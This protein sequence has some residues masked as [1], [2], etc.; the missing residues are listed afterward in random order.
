LSLAS[1]LAASVT[2]TS[3]VLKNPCEV[4]LVKADITSLNVD[5]VVNAA[6]NGL[7]RGAGVCGSIFQA[8][9]PRLDVACAALNGCATGDAVLTESFDMRNVKAIVHA[10]GPQVKGPLTDLH[11]HQLACCYARCLDV[12]S[13]HGLTSIVCF[14]L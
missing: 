2:T 10:V 11:R 14:S 5:A 9:G 7:C 12:A 6:N 3:A 13:Q 8:A 4:V 1:R